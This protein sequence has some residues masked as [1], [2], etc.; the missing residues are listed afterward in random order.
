MLRKE[1]KGRDSRWLLLSIPAI[2]HHDDEELKG[3]L[4]TK[5]RYKMEGVSDCI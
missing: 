5:L 4:E 1:N 2:V 3:Q